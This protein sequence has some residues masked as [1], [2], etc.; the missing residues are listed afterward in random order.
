MRS[1]RGGGRAQ[2]QCPREAMAEDGDGAW[3]SAVPI[4]GGDV[5]PAVGVDRIGGERLNELGEALLGTG[6][7]EVHGE[8]EYRWRANAVE[9][10]GEKDKVA[11]AGEAA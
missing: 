10:I 5:G 6:L 1:G 8:A 2:G 9:G 7:R 11:F 4:K 3:S